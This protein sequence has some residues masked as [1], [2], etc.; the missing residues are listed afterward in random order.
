M[1]L[2][3]FLAVFRDADF[4]QQWVYVGPGNFKNADRGKLRYPSTLGTLT[5][6]QPSTMA[7]RTSWRLGHQQISPLVTRRLH[8]RRLL[9][10]DLS[11]CKSE[12]LRAEFE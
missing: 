12:P 6:Q 4:R 11:L 7:E 2:L 5:Y 9:D 3:N 1:C 10:P 8:R